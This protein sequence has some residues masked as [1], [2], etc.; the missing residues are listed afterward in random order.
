MNRRTNGMAREREAGFTLMEMLVVLVVIGLI[1]AVAVPQVMK[2]LESAKHKAARIQL[3]TLGNSLN[4]YQLDMGGYPT[5]AQ[6]LIVLWK[7]A[8]DLPD[9][10]GPYVRREHQ[11][12]DPWN[13]PFIYRSPGTGHPYDL[14]SLGAD[15]KEGGRGDDADLSA[16]E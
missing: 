6:G 5:T 4:A 7:P 2:L 1:A 11:I 12:I 13:R 10:N 15:G 9:W 14:I 8:G 3:E 16:A